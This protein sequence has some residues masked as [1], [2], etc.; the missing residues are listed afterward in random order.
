MSKHALRPTTRVASRLLFVD[1]VRHAT[2]GLMLVSAVTILIGC[3][4]C[5]G[6]SGTGGS[7][8]D[9][10]MAAGGSGGGGG[11]GGSAA[12]GDMA[13]PNAPLVPDLGTTRAP[14]VYVGGYAPQIAAFTFDAQTGKLTATG[15]TAF[16]GSPSFLAVDPRHR[17]LYAVDEDNSEVAA[18]AIDGG[19]GALSAVGNRVSSGGSGPAHLSVDGTGK[20]V[21][22]ANYDSG[23]IAVLPIASNG[24][25]GAAA[26]P[27]KAGTNAHMIVTDPANKS[28]L[29][30]CLGSEYVA[31]YHFD[32]GTGKLTANTPATASPV[33]PNT[34][35]GKWGPRHLAFHPNGQWVYLINET[36]LTLTSYRYDA[37]AG[38]LAPQSTVSTLP[39]N[40][41]KPGYSTAEVVVHP[42]GKWVYGSNRGHNSI[43]VFAID[44]AGKA[45]LTTTVPSG[46]ATPRS[47]TIDPTGTWMLVANQD[48]NNVVVYRIDATTGVPAVVGTPVTVSKPAFVG[49]VSPPG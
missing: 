27:L 49:F 38:T 10:M 17:Y 25:V 3:N 30:P 13:D 21:L 11:H 42:T 46:G 39:P 23:H 6:G 5:G 2:L 9:G 18:F 43:A 20:W 44:G 14:F 33:V 22:T 45:T 1:G 35:A 37:A 31:Q 41:A 47:F 19:S 36:S 29:V 34:P 7:G 40:A 16:A 12:P 4:G 26:S 48:G 32:A 24:S 28:V 8:G 15:T